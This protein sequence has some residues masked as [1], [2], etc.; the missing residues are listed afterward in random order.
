MAGLNKEVWISQILEKFYPASS[1]LRYV[2]DMSVLVEND[3]INLAQAGVDPTVLVDN[4][5]YPIPSTT[6]TD[7]PIS[8]ELRKLETENTIIRRPDEIEH[9]YDKVESVIY[10]HRMALQTKSLELAA[11]AYA[12]V[13]DSADT[14]VVA[15]TGENNSTTGK[16]RIRIE[17]ILTLKRRFDNKDVPFEERYLVLHP[18]HVE[19]LILLD[20]KVFKDITDFKNGQ[21]LRF[22]GFNLLQ[23][24]RNAFYRAGLKM[25]FNP[26]T[27]ATDDFCSFAFH[28]AEVMKADGEL[29]MYETVDDP[30]ERG[31]IIGFD[32]RFLALPLR[33]KAIGAIIS[34]ANAA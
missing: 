1:F 3:K 14:P 10:G 30:K 15:V 7:S 32:K 12:P 5:A 8:L 31:T 20:T 18:S 16:K 6:R 27:L 11:Y 23:C 22:A 17:D 25:A 21:P 2:K 19:D 13:Q 9:S 33:N 26:A 4:N 29:Y 34:Q 24:R 28:S